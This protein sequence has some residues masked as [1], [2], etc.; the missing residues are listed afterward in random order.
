[1]ALDPRLLDQVL[2]APRALDV[3]ETPIAT[4]IVLRDPANAQTLA[5]FLDDPDS[6]AGVHARQILC[7]FGRSAVPFLM[8]ALA[9]SER[10]PD[11]RAQ[12]LDVLWSMLLAT[13]PGDVRSILREVAGDARTLLGDKTTIPDQA[14]AYIERDFQGRICD[15]AY[16]VLAHLVD[17]EIDL[18]RFR[19]MGADERDQ[20]IRRL[21]RRLFVGVA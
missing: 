1:V 13:A 17:R 9:D 2:R 8:R 3:G 5:P 10:S 4:A 21:E 11:G 16:L 18:S 20:E 12:G 6:T 7:R 19:A 15:R 14:L